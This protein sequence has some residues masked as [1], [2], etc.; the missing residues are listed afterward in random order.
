MKKC[1]TFPDLIYFAFGVDRPILKIKNS[2]K[3]NRFG[4]GIALHICHQILQ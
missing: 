2:L 1:E 4:R 3:E